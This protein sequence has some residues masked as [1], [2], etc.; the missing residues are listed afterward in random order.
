MG[1]TFVQ[2]C[3]KKYCNSTL[4][5]KTVHPELELKST[6]YLLTIIRLGRQATMPHATL[7]DTTMW[8]RLRYASSAF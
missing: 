2:Q 3:D 5:K 1:E 4:I 8:L 6:N 7:K